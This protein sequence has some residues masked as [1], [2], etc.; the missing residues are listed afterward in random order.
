MNAPSHRLLLACVLTLTASAVAQPL[1]P[2]TC[3]ASQLSLA[4][5]NE[6]GAFDGMMKSGTLLVLRNISTTPCRMSPLPPLSF[7]D[8]S[9]HE[10]KVSFTVQG[11]VGM[12]PGP[13]VLP[14]VIAP[15]AELT[16]A[17]RW[18]SGEVFDHSVCVSPTQLSVDIGEA[19]LH[20]I[21]QGQ[22]CGPDQDHVKVTVSRLA[23]DPVYKPTA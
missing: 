5:D 4:T 13:V 15:S 19:T 18:I 7:R 10:L 11:S 2:P 22:I 9:D 14:I 20:T 16:A 21:F 1:V 6:S 3:A 23:P 8:A 17:L 12:H